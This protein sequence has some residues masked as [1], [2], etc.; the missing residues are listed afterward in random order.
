MQENFL[1]RNYKVTPTHSRAVK[2]CDL[3]KFFLVRFQMVP[4]MI[5]G[6][7]IE[8]VSPTPEVQPKENRKEKLRK[9][10]R[11]KMS[12]PLPEPSE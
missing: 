7:E 12:S 10:R 2:N 5:P 1:A 4:E 6:I 9:K 8:S 3:E 11:L